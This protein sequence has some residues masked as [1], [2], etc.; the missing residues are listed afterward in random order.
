MNR[1]AIICSAAGAALL[2]AAGAVLAPGPLM[3][4]RLALLGGALGVVVLYD[5]RE[6]RIPNR[7]VLPAMAACIVL[8]LGE[9]V[10]P[11]TGLCLGAAFV[12]LMLTASLVAP[13]LLGMGDVKLALLILCALGGFASLALLIGFELYALVGVAL[14]IRRGRAA[15]GTA[16]P[17]APMLAASCLIAVLL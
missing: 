6:H 9:G 3:L 2:L 4:A 5:L 15:L 7:V 17:L 10:H 12:A 13:A 16:L 1:A 8:S 14:V 11:N